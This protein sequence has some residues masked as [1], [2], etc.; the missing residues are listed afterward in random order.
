[1]SAHP[2]IYLLCEVIADGAHP[3]PAVR[4]MR[5]QVAGEASDESQK[6]LASC[7]HGL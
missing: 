6:A 1:M 5:E 2:C 3:A 7:R 4:R